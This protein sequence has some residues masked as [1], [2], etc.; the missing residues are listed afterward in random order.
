[1]TAVIPSLAITA[2]LLFAM[3]GVMISKYH[4]EMGWGKLE[5]NSELY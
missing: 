2:L 1:M 3:L 5:I 4:K